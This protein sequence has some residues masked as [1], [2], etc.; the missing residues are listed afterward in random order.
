MNEKNKL[1]MWSYYEQLSL[2][3][4]RDIIKQLLALKIGFM[5]NFLFAFLIFGMFM[6]GFYTGGYSMTI[7]L[8]NYQIYVLI[9]NLLSIIESH[10][11]ISYHNG[12]IFYNDLNSNKL[13][14]SKL[15]YGITLSII[16]VLLFINTVYSIGIQSYF[17]YTNNY[18]EIVLMI[19]ILIQP[20][21]SQPMI[22]DFK[23]IKNC[24][25]MQSRYFGFEKLK[26]G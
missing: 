5:I 23:E 13:Y 3:E 2:E 18:S 26:L 1:L 6:L 20:L 14:I 9:A 15:V 19:V 17:C 11:A 21:N 12:M 8:F 24:L 10:L 22:K 25:L 4:K 7:F 16:K